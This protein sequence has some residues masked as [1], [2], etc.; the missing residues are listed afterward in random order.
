MLFKLGFV[1][2]NYCFRVVGTLLV[3]TRTKLVAPS[4][5]APGADENLQFEY[6]ASLRKH[7]ERVL[8]SLLGSMRAGI[9]GNLLFC[10]SLTE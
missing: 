4:A 5:P 8:A 6:E 10:F 3:R 9:Y 2:A 7:N 1:C